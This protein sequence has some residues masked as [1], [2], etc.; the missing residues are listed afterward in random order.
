M[1][2]SLVVLGVMLLAATT[3]AWAAEETK[4]SGFY[5]GLNTGYLA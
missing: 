1:K 4:W 2:K 5:F 3:L